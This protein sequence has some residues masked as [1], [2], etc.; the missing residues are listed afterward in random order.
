MELAVAR[1][2]GVAHPGAARGRDALF[3]PVQAV[4]VALA[5]YKVSQAIA[6]DVCHD[7]LDAGCAQVELRVPCPR[8]RPGLLGGL[9]P[10][11]R[12]HNVEPTVAS[13]VTGA[14]PVTR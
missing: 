1:V 14:H 5:H 2:V 3:Q 4:V 11:A 6:I 13:Y 10:P 9:E 12:E 8:L 7:D